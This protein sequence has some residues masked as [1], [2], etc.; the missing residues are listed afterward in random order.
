MSAADFPAAAE[1]A[2]FVYAEARLLDAG[3]YEEW[4]QLFAAGGRYWVPLSPSQTGSEAAQSIADEDLLLLRIRV[5]RLAH[6]RAY[7]LQPP[8]ACRHV[9]QAPHIEAA[10]PAG[11]TVLTCTSFMYAESKGDEQ[12]VLFGAARHRLRVEGGR[13]RIALKRIDLLNAGAA[14]PAIYLFM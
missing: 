2:A 10:D 11:G 1:I 4:L 8:V 9:L 13:L 6:P 12:L 7:S 14:L 3:R 5:A